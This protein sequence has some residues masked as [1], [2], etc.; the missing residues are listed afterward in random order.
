[1]KVLGVCQYDGKFEEKPF[2]KIMMVVSDNG[3]YPQLINVNPEVYQAT[4]GKLQGKEVNLYYE[5]RY[6]KYRVSKIEVLD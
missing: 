1:M 2:T 4:G 6:G 5:N 3:R